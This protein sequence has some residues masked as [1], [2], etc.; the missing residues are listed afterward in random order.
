MGYQGFEVSIVD[1]RCVLLA[2]G[3]SFRG[4]GV[5]QA[6]PTVGRADI[7]VKATSGKQK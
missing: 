2:R 5:R 1:G 3:V 7:D 6:V 4:G